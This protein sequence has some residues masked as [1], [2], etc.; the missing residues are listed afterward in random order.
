MTTNDEM[1]TDDYDRLGQS[2]GRRLIDSANDDN[3]MG[4]N[5]ESATWYDVT[6]TSEENDEDFVAGVCAYV[7]TAVLIGLSEA[8]KNKVSPTTNDAE[9]GRP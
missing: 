8:R 1:T 6:K 7:R 9:T 2:Y 4:G 5:F 3:T